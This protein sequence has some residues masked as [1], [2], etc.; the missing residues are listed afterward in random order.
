MDYGL[1]FSCEGAVVNEQAIG[2]SKLEAKVLA[3]IFGNEV[4]T[5]GKDSEKIVLPQLVNCLP[6]A[7]CVRRRK[8]FLRNLFYRNTS[9][10]S[11]VLGHP[12]C[13]SIWTRKVLGKE[14]IPFSLNTGSS[15][16]RTPT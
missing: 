6:N 11:G 10:K 3:Y 1:C 9:E 7:S 14:A 15:A 5:R 2:N 4:N 8:D 12:F 16:D 13:I